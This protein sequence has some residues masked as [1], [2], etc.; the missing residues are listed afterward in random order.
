VGFNTAGDWSNGAPSNSL[1]ACI[2]NGSAVILPGA[3]T[4]NVLN[5]QLNAGNALISNGTLEASGTQIINGGVILLKG[6][7]EL[8]NGAQITGGGA[9]NLNG[10]TLSWA[11]NMSFQSDNAFTGYGTLSG[12]T[13]G[14]TSFTLLSGG[15]IVPSGLITLNSDFTD[16]GTV[17]VSKGNSLT[18]V[19]A[20]G[21]AIG[22]IADSATGT[23]TIN[24][25]GTVN[26]TGDLDVGFPNNLNGVVDITG[27]GSSLSIGGNLFFSSTG[28]SA[29]MTVGPGATVSVADLV[30]QQGGTIDIQSGSNFDANSYF[31]NGGDTEVDGSLTVSSFPIAPDSGGLYVDF[32]GFLTG[33]GGTITGSLLN[34]GVLEP[35][36]RTAPGTLTVNGTVT[37]DSPSTF[38]EQIAGLN[39]FGVLLDNTGNIALG[40][41]LDVELQ[42]GY[43]PAVG[44][45]YTFIDPP[46]YSGTF[47]YDNLPT[48]GNGDEFI[49]QYNADN[50]ELCVV[51]DTNPTCGAAPAPATAPEPR[52]MVL[53]GTVIAAA[54]W[55]RRRN[56]A[57]Q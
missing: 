24:S 36:T 1:N 38:I 52:S 32:F 41:T 37:L 46:S 22:G 20:G 35:G 56:L 28:G 45:T 57:Q 6:E 31:I 21:I 7:L 48:L 25:G 23:L 19:G 51:T 54:L 42:N 11:S 17:T 26:I 50:A 39:N 18:I 12:G 27:T 9:I 47:T 44:S 16:D 14:T 43:N 49:V 53:L 15:T 13:S 5:L 55:Y 40:G 33:N 34:D 3:Q 4:G 29:P 8:L 2:I 10:G 30:N